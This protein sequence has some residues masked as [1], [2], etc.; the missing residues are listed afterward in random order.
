L[1]ENDRLIG[2]DITDGSKDVMLFTSAGKAIRFNEEHV[3]AMGRTAGGVR[4]VKIQDDQKVISLIIVDEGTVLTATENGYGK[5]TDVSQYPAHGRGGQGVVSIQ[6]SERNGDVI[7]ATLV[8]DDNEIMLITD[9]GTLV[10]TRVAE[11]SVQGRN[12]QGVRLIGLS[13]GEKLVG[14]ERIEEQ[15]SEESEEQEPEQDGPE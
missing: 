7:G 9:G 5:R 8:K 2:V 13:G 14:V 15:E 3:R 4:G 10:R 6:V 12:T 1:R 11:I